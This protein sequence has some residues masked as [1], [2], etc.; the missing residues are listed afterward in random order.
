MLPRAPS[1]AAAAAVSLGA[2]LLLLLLLA[3]RDEGVCTH[4]GGGVKGAVALRAEAAAACIPAAAVLT[5]APQAD[6]AADRACSAVTSHHACVRPVGGCR[7]DRQG[8]G[9]IDQRADG[10]CPFRPNM[11]HS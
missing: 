10:A 1:T 3:V 5:V 8:A 11:C 2:L 7:G 9:T 6:E 4:G